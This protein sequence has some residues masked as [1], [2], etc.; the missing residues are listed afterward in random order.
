M[1]PKD[2]VDKGV[3][4]FLM[5]FKAM[6]FH[7]PSKFYA[8][9]HTHT[10]DRTEKSPAV[11]KAVSITKGLKGMNKFNRTL[12]WKFKNFAD[13]FELLKIPALKFTKIV[14][15]DFDIN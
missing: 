14:S 11:Q 12:L 9:M 5:S 15:R 8:L 10:W 2:A 3:H 7:V 4:V 1:Q 13:N 6:K